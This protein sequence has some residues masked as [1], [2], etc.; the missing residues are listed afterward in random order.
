[1]NGNGQHQGRSV[2]FLS[3]LHDGELDAAERARFETHRAHCAECRHA[4]LEFEDTLSLFRATRSSPPRSD[5]AAR[6][7]RKVQ[8]ANR[9]RRPFGAPFRIDLAWTALLLTALLALIITMPIAVRRSEQPST[10]KAPIAAPARMP[11]PQEEPRMPDSHRV[12]RMKSKTTGAEARRSVAPPRS[13]DSIA[14]EPSAG[15]REEREANASSSI[16]VSAEAPLVAAGGAGRSEEDAKAGLP[17]LP[18]KTSKPPRV[19]IEAIDGFGP[20]PDPVGEERFDLPSALRGERYV[21]TVDSQGSVRE[22]RP[23]RTK[24]S[25][26]GAAELPARPP[27]TLSDESA[28]SHVLR[29]LRF[30]P[31]NRPRLLLVRIE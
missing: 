28:A 31:G 13:K 1:M 19:L 21:L 25:V 26:R 18:Q 24:R 22:V 8:S 7:L 12:A 9:V 5:L 20:A 14:A 17:A 29:T 30:R 2:D 27:E 10:V 16:T 6:I 23:Y 11:A 4:A 3:R 15:R